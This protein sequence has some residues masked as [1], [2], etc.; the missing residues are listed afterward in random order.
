MA[1]INGIIY[2]VTHFSITA[3][4]ARTLFGY[5]IHVDSGVGSSASEMVAGPVS[6]GD[7][8]PYHSL[9]LARPQ[10][11]GTNPNERFVRVRTFQPLGIDAKALGLSW[12]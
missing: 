5:E 10:R 3:K 6:I 12:Q 1:P 8:S 2:E 7:R 9:T 4:P 11:A